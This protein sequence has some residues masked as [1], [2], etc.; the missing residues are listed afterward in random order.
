VKIRYVGAEVRLDPSDYVFVQ[1][2]GDNMFKVS[3]HDACRHPSTFIMSQK[4]LVSVCTQISKLFAHMEAARAE[5][6][7]GAAAD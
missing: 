4:Q 7:V 3:F 6:V 5:E 1:A 2:H